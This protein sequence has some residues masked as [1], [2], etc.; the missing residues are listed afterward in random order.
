MKYKGCSVVMAISEKK[1]CERPHITRDQD[2][3]NVTMIEIK[4]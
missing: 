4:C 1:Q 3:L 2:I